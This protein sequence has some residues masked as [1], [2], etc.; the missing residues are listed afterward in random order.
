[1]LVV[2]HVSVQGLRREAL[3]LQIPFVHVGDARTR[4]SYF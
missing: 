4:C 2:T 3:G 1:M